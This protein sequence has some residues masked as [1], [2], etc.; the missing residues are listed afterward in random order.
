M[1][2]ERQKQ[3]RS[4]IDQASGEKAITGKPLEKSATDRPAQR[5]SK[6]LSLIKKAG[7]RGLL[8]TN[9][10][11]VTYLTGFS[12]DDSYLVV[13]P[14]K[15]VLLTDS[16]FTTQIEQECPGLPYET[17]TARKPMA[18]LVGA[19]F[20]SSGSL[21]LGFESQHVSFALHQDWANR[22]KSITLVPTTD[23]V[24]QLR[25]IK[26]AS[27]IAET[28]EAV[29]MAQRG[30]EVVKSLFVPEMTEA[31]IAADLEHAMRRFGAAK[32]AFD[33]IIAVG[34]RAALPHAR[35]GNSQLSEAGFVLLDWGA[36]TPKGYKSDITRVVA[37][38]KVP[39]QIEKAYRVVLA[40]QLA[41]IALIRPGASCQAVDT[42]ARKVIE[43]AGYGKFFGH[44]LGHGIGLDVH[45]NPRFS[46]ISTDELK[47]GQIVTVEPGIY[48]PELGGIRI[49]DD[50]LVTK[51]GHEVLTSLPK[52]FEEFQA[53]R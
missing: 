17:R 47:V 9:P 36:S 51:D 35:A 33:P 37:T 10:K 29:Q 5:R 2:T 45:E 43:D 40:A 53:R 12:G 26:D 22:L 11:N 8:V 48:F 4:V 50:V 13:T 3:E 27:E 30:F 49:E 41:A 32:V 21:S 39:V 18:E 28:R 25:S 23:L 34:P 46:P 7:L 1:A 31:A 20:K 19:F 16:R 24:E 14:E 38:G 15:T 52:S 6:L 44:G 42:A